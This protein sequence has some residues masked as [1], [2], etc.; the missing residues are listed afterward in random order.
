MNVIL[1]YLDIRY[2]LSVFECFEDKSF[3]NMYHFKD[4]Y[5][6]LIILSAQIYVLLFIDFPLKNM[7]PLRVTYIVVTSFVVTDI[8]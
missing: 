5:Y 3:A 8:L 2:T 6:I 1:N 7:Y 4:L